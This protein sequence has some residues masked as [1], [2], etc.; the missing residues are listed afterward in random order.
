MLTVPFSVNLLA[1]LIRFSNAC[2]SRIWSAWIVPISALQWTATWLLFLAASGSMVLTTSSISGARAKASRFSSIRPASILE[3][4]RMSLINA[5]KWRPAPSTRSS[6]STSCFNAS[7]SSRSIS[8]TPMMAFSG[9]RSSWLILARNCDLCWLGCKTGEQR[10]LLVIE[11]LGLLAIDVDR[12]NH[13]VILEHWHAEHGA[14][15]AKLH[16]CNE[17]GLAVDVALV[18]CNVGNVDRLLCFQHATKCGARSGAHWSTSAHLC[19]VRRRIENRGRPEVVALAKIQGA[20]LG[21]ANFD[22]I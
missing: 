4:S 5:S 20:E 8:L 18:G 12:T 10:D 19:A 1:L 22:G 3:R 21:F 13:V 16:R 9:V 15:P 6:G 17:Q 7:A 11:R 2:R 14:K